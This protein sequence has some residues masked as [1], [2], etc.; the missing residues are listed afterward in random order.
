[1]S[2]IQKRFSILGNDV[3]NIRNDVQRIRD[4][5]QDIRDDVQ[6]I[7]NKNRRSIIININSGKLTECFIVGYVV[8]ALYNW[9]YE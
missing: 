7:Q 4:D 2:R 6:D 3:Q 5:I 8:Y 1:M 9:F